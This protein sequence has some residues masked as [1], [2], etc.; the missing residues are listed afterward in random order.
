MVTRSPTTPLD[1]AADAATLL[2]RIGFA[3]LVVAV[4]VAAVVA[5]RATVVLVPLGAALLVIAALLDGASPGLGTTLRRIVPSRGGL[6]A[7]ALIGWAA[8]SILWSPFPATAGDKI[9]NVLGAV[10]VTLAGV[11]ALP[12]RMRAS[13][14]YL[15]GIGAGAAAV[16]A[17]AV[18]LAISAAD[19]AE[20]ADASLDRGLVSLAVTIWPA[21]AWLV[22][23]DR[24]MM[25]LTLAAVA[26]AAV[27]LGPSPT[28]AFALA[29]GGLAYAATT[30]RPAAVAKALAAGIA[31]L[32]LAAPLL[33]FVLRPFAKAIFGLTHPTTAAVR[34]WA[35][36]VR[37]EPMRL[38]TGH[39]LD[40]ALRGRSVG[41]LPTDAPMSLL[42]EVWY[43]LGLV[44]AAALA[45]LFYLTVR[46]AAG[47]QGLLLPALMAAFAAVFSLG[48]L[49]I[50][51]AQS[52]WLSTLGIVAIAFVAV[53]RGQFR[54]TRPKA[55]LWQAANDR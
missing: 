30:I 23:R 26:A 12:E 15:T 16:F 48:C 24:R 52:W 35:D 42:F 36:V 27:L 9:V 32:I 33:P 17:I 47:V 19:E 34:A 39:G 28:P 13:N 20:H 22:S 21:I 43:E 46:A 37:S 49:G 8:L 41:L 25:A 45:A 4:P 40:T 14:L 11:A 10:L 38:V 44:G 7:L 5:R 29:L 18:A 55:R 2:R 6:L 1:P 51:M 50:G 31:G 54:T 3:T 53:E